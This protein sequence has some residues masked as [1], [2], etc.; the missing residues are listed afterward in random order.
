MTTGKVILVTVLAGTLSILVAVF[1][2]R[3]LGEGKPLDISLPKIVD[4]GGDRL[5]SL[6]EFRLPDTEGRE[7]ASSAWAGKVLVVSFWA[8]WCPPCRNEMPLFVEAQAGNE[9]VQVVGIAIDEKDAVV[10]FLSEHPVNYPILLGDT[11]AIEMS[12]RLGNRLQGLPFTVIFDQLGRRAYAQ[13]GEV[14]R[15]VLIEQLAPLLPKL[16]LAQTSGNA[17]RTSK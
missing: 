3:W 6:P 13:V 5:D 2:Q 9:R 17:Q 1:G 8:T 4:R 11:Q 10:R 15:A 14:T 12:R 16:N 7:I